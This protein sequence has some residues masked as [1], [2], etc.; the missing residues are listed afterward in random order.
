LQPYYHN[1]ACETLACVMANVKHR[2]AGLTSS[3]SDLFTSDTSRRQIIAFLESIDAL[4]PPPT[5]L[6]IFRHDIAFDPPTIFVGQTVTI[7]ANISF[8]GPKVPTFD[9]G[10]LKVTFFDGVP[11]QAGTTEIGSANLVGV[12]VDFG[13]A[14]V[15]V[16]WQVPN[17]VGT[18]RVTVVVD[19]TNLFAEER[20]RDNTA[21]RSV[22]VRAIPP[23]R[24]LPQVTSVK[25]N[26]DAVSTTSNDVAI[27]FAAVDPPSPNPAPTSGL[28]SFCVVRY[29]YRANIRRWVEENCRFQP[30]PTANSDGTFTVQTSLPDR[31]G[32]AYAFIWVKDEAG[33]ISQRPG[34]DFI[35]VIEDG[36]ISLA[37]NDTRILRISLD[38]GQSAEVTVTPTVGDIDLSAFAG[39]AANAPR[40]DVSASNGL[41]PETVAFSVPADGTRTIFQ[42]EIRA[43]VFSRFTLGVSRVAL[44]GAPAQE[45]VIAPGKE[46]PETPFVAGPPSLT[47]AIEDPEVPGS[48]LILRLPMMIR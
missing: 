5:N 47:S 26:N 34:F 35:N 14:T 12:D 18:R 33:N 2:T 7:S 4:T 3:Q 32:I 29:S 30:L 48:G 37:R 42:I 10:P 43:V 36:Q 19:S 17:N 22:F 28:E 16:P 1:G 40:V 38:P 27:T 6:R 46:I 31:F 23:D 15:S 13:Q 41:T 21:T 44:T 9:P 39:V 45:D 25:I 11:G 24:V 20:E 8:F